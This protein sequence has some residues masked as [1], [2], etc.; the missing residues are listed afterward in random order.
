MSAS[1]QTRAR[2]AP[3]QRQD[4]YIDLTRDS[5]GPIGEIQTPQRP[6]P[7]SNS[8]NSTTSSTSTVGSSAG[9]V[10]DEDAQSTPAT[11]GTPIDEK[12]EFSRSEADPFAASS[13]NHFI[14]QQELSPRKTQLRRKRASA[15]SKTQEADSPLAKTRRQTRSRSSTS[16]VEN[17]ESNLHTSGHLSP[18]FSRSP[19]RRRASSRPATPAERTSLNPVNIPGP[20]GRCPHIPGAFESQSIQ[21]ELQTE[22]NIQ[23]APQIE[24]SSAE[25]LDSPDQP[26]LDILEDDFQR[27]KFEKFGSEK[28]PLRSRVINDT[29][30]DCLKRPRNPKYKTG[31]VYIFESPEHAP[32]HVKI[33]IGHEEPRKR[34]KDWE[35]CH[36][37]LLDAEDPDRNAFDY[38]SIVES[39]IK[40]ELHDCRKRFECTVCPRKKNGQQKKHEEWYEID[41]TKAL[42]HVARWRS[43]IKSKKPFEGKGELT[44]YWRWRVD[45]LPKILERVDWDSWTDPSL[46]DYWIYKLKTSGNKCLRPLANH[47]S[48]KDDWFSLVG[49]IIL[50]VLYINFG[51]FGVVWGILGLIAL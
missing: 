25:L 10:F 45:E 40:A 39:L 20:D 2:R 24:T 17:S 50:L 7:Y 34:K 43:W 12:P 23:E 15:K 44:P 1:N 21:A 9:S 27:P 31:W 8:S 16:K 35:R 26:R 47:L 28:E 22:N 48:R 18:S 46:F 29:I 5:P 14:Q 13:S 41:T 37:T 19:A 32:K 11:P 36:G 4:N 6:A 33:G 42:K 38:Y 3:S 30:Y 49:T 51:P